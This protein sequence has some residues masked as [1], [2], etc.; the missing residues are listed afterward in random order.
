MIKDLVVR[1]ELEACVAAWDDIAVIS[2]GLSH[3]PR[4]S[5]L[6]QLTTHNNSR[7]Q[8]ASCR[9]AAHRHQPCQDA[10][11]LVTERLAKPSR[12]RRD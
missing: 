2:R 8:R 11:E 5:C 1:A 7:G 6:F 12:R 3:R 9:G 10:R 4:S